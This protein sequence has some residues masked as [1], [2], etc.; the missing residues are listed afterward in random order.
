MYICFCTAWFYSV[1]IMKIVLLV[2]FLVLNKLL[3]IISGLIILRVLVIKILI[4][5]FIMRFVKQ[6]VYLIR[7]CFFCF[8]GR[9]KKID[10]L[11][12]SGFSPLSNISLITSVTLTI[13]RSS[14]ADSIPITILSHPIAFFIFIFTMLY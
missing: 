10:L 7:T 3:L 1:L 4:I 13:L 2:P 14:K 5:S 8:F 6:I 11:S 9:A 12:S